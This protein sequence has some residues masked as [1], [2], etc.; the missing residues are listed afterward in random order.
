[1]HY[2]NIDINELPQY[3]LAH[4]YRALFKTMVLEDEE[5]VKATKRACVIEID[6]KYDRELTSVYNYGESQIHFIYLPLPTDSKQ[7]ANNWDYYNRVLLPSLFKKY[8]CYGF[9]SKYG[10][11]NLD[12]A[13]VREAFVKSRKH[14]EWAYNVFD[15][16]S[17]LLPPIMPPSNSVNDMEVLIACM[18]NL[19][20]SSPGNSHCYSQ[21]VLGNDQTWNMGID[22]HVGHPHCKRPFFSMSHPMT[23]EMFSL[24]INYLMHKTGMTLEEIKEDVAKFESGL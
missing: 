5:S 15:C 12:F 8:Q 22:L 24:P 6:P 13:L 20:I 14:L 17:N 7:D 3:L 16:S 19:R 1:M 21:A 2:T 23:E 10:H 11:N 4:Y 9:F 18:L